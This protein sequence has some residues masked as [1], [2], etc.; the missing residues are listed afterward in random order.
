MIW[1][2]LI[3]GAVGGLLGGPWG[4]AA[5]AALGAG[6]DVLRG[7]EAPPLDATMT[8]RPC[9]DGVMIEARLIEAVEGGRALLVARDPEGVLLRA[10]VP[11]F[12]GSEQR[13]QIAA[14]V[15]N[16]LVR[17]FVPYGTIAARGLREVTVCLR[18]Y[19]SPVENE[20]DLQGEE[21][22][23][24]TWPDEPYSAARFW[25]P[26]LGLCM[27]VA[28]ADGLVE[29]VEVRAV[30]ERIS[31]GLKIPPEELDEVTEIL[32]VEPTAPLSELLAELRLRAPLIRPSVL[33]SALADVA[34]ANGDLHEAEVAI[35][36]EVARLLGIEGA[37]WRALAQQLR[38]ENTDH[39][40]H[41]R[42]LLGL[43]TT[44]SAA[45]IEG[46]YDL[47]MHQYSPD[48]VAGL[49][50][51]FRD[52]AWRRTAALKRARAALLRAVPPPQPDL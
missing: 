24:I 20:L 11:R 44:P 35:I 37:R 47:Q 18:V 13:F 33:L 5:G 31:A 39:L 46:A 49:P 9:P 23:T 19:L 45:E 21:S 22:L 50:E 4:L 42:R 25:R 16:D 12:A 26:M 17:C 34:R 10:A 36:V 27:A 51:E 29:R 43:T 40:S 41:Y 14:E 52:L 1:E 28:R 15:H 7:R 2:A 38:L 3:G 32:R 48:R 30:R 6:W 8:A